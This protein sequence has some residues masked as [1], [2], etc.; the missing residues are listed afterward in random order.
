MAVTTAPTTTSTTTFADN[1]AEDSFIVWPER[2][3]CVHRRSHTREFYLT[4]A[5]QVKVIELGERQL[6]LW[7]EYVHANRL[8]KELDTADTTI[9]LT[10]A[11]EEAMTRAEM[12]YGMY[13]EAASTEDDIHFSAQ[14]RWFNTHDAE[15]NFINSFDLPHC[16]QHC[17]QHT[18]AILPLR[19]VSR[20]APLKRRPKNRRNSK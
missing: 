2:A 20:T 13:T 3:R 1:F 19:L 14:C 4:I 7:T 17:P 18:N 6:T 16:P 9:E 11:Y 10:Y 5:E 8:G 12:F 15:G